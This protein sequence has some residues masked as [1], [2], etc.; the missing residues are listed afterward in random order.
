MRRTAFIGLMPGVANTM[1]TRRLFTNAKRPNSSPSKSP[2]P[3]PVSGRF[4]PAR[5][6]TNVVNRT[7]PH[8]QRPAPSGQIPQ[9]RK[10]AAPVW[11]W[12]RDEIH[13]INDVAAEPV[14]G[15]FWRFAFPSGTCPRQAWWD[16]QKP[17]GAKPSELRWTSGRMYP[18]FWKRSRLALALCGMMSSL[19]GGAGVLSFITSS[20]N[21][22]LV[23]TGMCLSVFAALALPSFAY[24][25]YRSRTP[26]E[27]WMG[28]VGS[29]FRRQGDSMMPYIHPT[30]EW[31]Y[32]WYLRPM[33]VKVGDIVQFR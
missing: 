1:S 18:H 13:H 19:L 9:D 22:G 23:S 28:L 31:A 27:A 21:D 16:R 2:V 6:G 17:A 30:A 8:R 15:R 4:L 11:T 3:E 20:H 10:R 12:T 24:G 5:P 7:P 25:M 32:G 14:K 26:Q 33:S 29:A